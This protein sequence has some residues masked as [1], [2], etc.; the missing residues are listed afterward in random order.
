MNVKFILTAASYAEKLNLTTDPEEQ[1]YFLL[2]IIGKTLGKF[3]T[4]RNFVIHLSRLV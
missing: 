1:K 2:P 4:F 3:A